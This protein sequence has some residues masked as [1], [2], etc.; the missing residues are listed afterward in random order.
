MGQWQA[1]LNA[2]SDEFSGE[3]LLK[4]QEKLQELQSA[5]AEWSDLILCV[6][7]RH[8]DSQEGDD[9]ERPQTP[10]SNSRKIMLSVNSKIDSFMKNVTAR[11]CG[12]NGRSDFDKDF[13]VALASH[14]F[15]TIPVYAAISPLNVSKKWIIASDSYMY[16]M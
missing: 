14:H 10:T 16:I 5:V 4:R 9:P 7:R 1:A 11:M 3:L 13:V 8:P 12:E 2:L 6:M 15:I